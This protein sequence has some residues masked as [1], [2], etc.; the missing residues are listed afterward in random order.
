M[1]LNK[2]HAI[3]LLEL[4][5]TIAIVIILMAI[6]FNSISSLQIENQRKE[7]TS[8]LLKLK[9]NIEQL[10]VSGYVGSA[11]VSSIMDV[12][13]KI[14]SQNFPNLKYYNI[15]ITITSGTDA[16]YTLIATAKEPLATNDKNCPTIT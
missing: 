15:T 6:S 9:S 3:S 5:I 7:A 12:A 8:E 14:N 4:M 10:A 13:A 2:L 16:S 1:K 11:Q